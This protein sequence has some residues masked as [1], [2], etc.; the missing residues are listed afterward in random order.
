M[1]KPWMFSSRYP[2]MVA[3][4]TAVQTESNTITVAK[5]TGTSD[6]DL[7]VAFMSNYNAGTTYLWTGA[8]GWTEA[9]DLNAKPSARV[10]YKVASSEGA[11]YDFVAGQSLNIAYIVTIR[12]GT[13]D[14]VGSFASDGASIVAP[15]IT[16]AVENSLLLAFMATPAV[17]P[18]NAAP[19][20]PP[21]GMNLV[22]NYSDVSA[23]FQQRVGAGLTGTRTSTL[24]A[25]TGVVTGILVSI[26][27]T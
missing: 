12:R 6:G 15:E 27:P 9:A 21:S 7:M 22:C 14:A 11:S 18:L 20:T 24:A 2:V 3:Y 10:A 25:G 5:P 23:V 19:P 4:E 8:A 17:H 16:C 26:S 1:I 13:Y